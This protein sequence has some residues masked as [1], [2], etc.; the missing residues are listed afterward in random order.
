VGTPAGRPQRA[1]SLQPIV[2]SRICS[3]RK[4]FDGCG[5]QPD[6]NDGALVCGP[7]LTIRGVIDR[8]IF[9]LGG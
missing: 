7:Q 3:T 8:L 5:V 6:N 2:R 9:N 4:R 1:P